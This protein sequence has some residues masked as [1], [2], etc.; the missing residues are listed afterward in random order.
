[1][2][3]AGR[4]EFVVT[5]SRN[6]PAEFRTLCYNSGP[7]GDPDPM[8]VLAHLRNVPHA[9]HRAYAPAPLRVARPLPRNLFTLPL[10]PVAATRTVVFNEDDNAMYINGQAFWPGAAPMFT[11][12]VGTI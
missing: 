11:V 9:F 1:V 7:T 12:R 5:G 3:P 4:A 10:P 8:I 6:G 2:P